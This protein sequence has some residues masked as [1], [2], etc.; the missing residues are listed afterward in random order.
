MEGNTLRLKTAT[1][2]S[3][4]RSRRPSTR[5]K[6]GRSGSEAGEAAGVFVTSSLNP[7]A[8]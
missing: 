8:P 1:T 7:V 2:K 4:T 3:S 6:C 5:L